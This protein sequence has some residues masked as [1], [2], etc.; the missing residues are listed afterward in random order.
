MIKYIKKLIKKQ[1]LLRKYKNII[2]DHLFL[3]D[4]I[5][6]K[7]SSFYKGV[8]K[9]MIYFVNCYNRLKKL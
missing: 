2:N 4:G 9:Y 6:D 7:N 5:N 1:R 8:E 3:L